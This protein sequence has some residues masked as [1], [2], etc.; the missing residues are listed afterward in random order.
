MFPLN[1]MPV[2]DIVHRRSN[3]QPQTSLSSAAAETYA[4][5]EAS[6]DARLRLWVSEKLGYK[7]VWPAVIQVDNAAALSFQKATKANTKLKGVYNLREK[8]VQELRD[9]SKIATKT[10]DTAIDVSD[11]L[12][13]CL[14]SATRSALWM[15]VG[16]IAS[17]L[18]NSCVRHLGGLVITG[19]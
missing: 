13:R 14:T 12:A 11:V 17:G 8:W 18:R 2:H 16:V 4:L 7:G 15:Q 3:K 5:S 9:D 19:A 1:G 10:V 6:K